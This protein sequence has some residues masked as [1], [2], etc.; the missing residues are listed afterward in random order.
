MSS[1]KKDYPWIQLPLITCAPMLPVATGELAAAVSAAGGIGFIGLGNNIHT[2]DDQLTLAAHHLQTTHAKTTLQTPDAS[3]LP[4]GV[5]FLNW[6]VN[7]D[8]ALPA[9]KKHVPAAIWLFGAARETMASLYASWITR[10]HQETAGR[11]KVWVQVGSVADAL[12]LTAEAPPAHRPDV[13]VLQGVDAGGHGLKNG[14]GI[15]TLLPE[16]RDTLASHGELSAIPLIAAG[17]IVDGRGVAAALCLGADGVAMGTRFLACSQTA[18][19]KGYQD[20]LIRARDGGQSTARTTIY[21][22]LRGYVEWPEEYDGRGMVNQSYFDDQAGMSDEENR[23]LYEAEKAKGDAGWGVKGRMT[24]YAGTGVGL[25][26]TV[27]T[28]EEIVSSAR[29]EA[30]KLVKI[31]N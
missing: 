9:I 11:T 15:I 16:V 14:A 31:D 2:L 4:V 18:I 23:R 27:S 21:D 8:D 20:E 29:E 25:V 24:S 6:G 5:G 26:K 19:M 3:I 22:R 7:L 1:L 12:T 13:L 28:A 10:V 17:G 30:R